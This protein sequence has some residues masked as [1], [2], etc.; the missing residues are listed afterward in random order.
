[1]PEPFPAAGGKRLPMLRTFW[2]LPMAL[3][4]AAG[5]YPERVLPAQNLAPYVATPDDVV[6]RMLTFAKVTKEDVVYDLGCGDGRIP[7]AAA[8]KFGAKGVGFD[9]EPQ[10]IDL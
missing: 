2:I 3:S 9:L 8:R 4:A 10:L 5:L 6:D 1:M 7:I